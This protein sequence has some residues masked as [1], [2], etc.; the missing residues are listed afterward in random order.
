MKTISAIV[1]APE[2]T[3]M[4][5][6]TVKITSA[7]SC[8]FTISIVVLGS[9]VTLPFTIAKLSPIAWN[10]SKVAV[11]L[12]STSPVNTA[13]CANNSSRSVWFSATASAI[14]ETSSA[15]AAS[16]AA[17]SKSATAASI[18]ARPSAKAVSIWFDKE[19]CKEFTVPANVDRSLW[20][21]DKPATVEASELIWFSRFANWSS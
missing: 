20:T 13:D 17:A 4:S 15:E 18:S 9:I 16:A 2:V 5:L 21:W 3:V 14:A 11:E 12:I 8:T 10:A 6:V 1:L 7:T 19:L